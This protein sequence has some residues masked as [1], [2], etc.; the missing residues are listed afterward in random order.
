VKDAE[1][2]CK[3]AEELTALFLKNVSE[4]L[5]G[6]PVVM[7]LPVWYAQKRVIHLQKLWGRLAG[8]NFKPVLPPH[9]TPAVSGH[10]SLLYR[11]SDQFVGREIVLLEAISG[12]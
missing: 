10:F 12:K 1:S 8:L 5:P 4:T 7:I 3:E 6:V 11:R 9:T 2:Y